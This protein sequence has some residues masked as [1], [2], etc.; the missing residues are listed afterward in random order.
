MSAR[1]ACRGPCARGHGR[2]IS[3]HPIIY[4]SSTSLPTRDE[5]PLLRC[6]VVAQLRQCTGVRERVPGRT[7][8]PTCLSTESE[9]Q[10]GLLLLLVSRQT[11]HFLR[12]ASRALRDQVV[13]S[14]LRSSALASQGDLRCRALRTSQGVFCCVSPPRMQGPVCQ[15]PRTPNISSPHHLSIIHISPDSG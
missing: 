10:V 7:S 13:V 4:L 3:L 5:G 11:S 12:S 1:R 14:P 2:L 9:Y 15:R 8:T 6:S